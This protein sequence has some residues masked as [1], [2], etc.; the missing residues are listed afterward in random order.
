[1]SATARKHLSSS[2]QLRV[3]RGRYSP[4]GSLASET[5]ARSS[6][7]LISYKKVGKI[8]PCRRFRRI[9]WLCAAL[10]LAASSLAAQETPQPK[11]PTGRVRGRV[12]YS[13]T[14]RPVRLA[15][16]L[17]VRA[18]REDAPPGDR[19]GY[20]PIP[21]DPENQ[22]AATD[23][24]G[25]FE[26]EKAPAGKY[27][28]ILFG[29]DLVFDTGPD[30]AGDLNPASEDLS[31]RRLAEHFP[32]VTVRENDTAE[33]QLTGRRGG[34]IAGRVTKPDGSPV[35]EAEVTL[36]RRSA[37]GKITKITTLPFF[38][39]LPD[40]SRLG[41]R[42]Q[43][44]AQGF[45]RLYGLPAGEYLLRAAPP[46][47]RVENEEE[48][49]PEAAGRLFYSYFPAGRRAKQATPVVVQEGVESPGVDV[50]LPDLPARALGGAVTLKDAPVKGAK[51]IVRPYD[52]DLGEELSGFSQPTDEAG[53]WQLRGLPDGVY[54]LSVEL[55]EAQAKAPDG[56]FAEANAFAGET[57][58]ITLSGD[59]TDVKLPLKAGGVVGGTV[60]AVG[61]KEKHPLQLTLIPREK[62][63]PT[64]EELK[65]F[66]Q[67][68]PPGIPREEL[69]EVWESYAPRPPPSAYL[70][71]PGAFTIARLKP[72][73]YALSLSDSEYYIKQITRNGKP[74]P[75]EP[76]SVGAGEEMTDLRIEVADDKASLE[77]RAFLD[78]AH[79]QPLARGVVYLCAVKDRLLIGG[80]RMVAWTDKNGAF[81][82]NAPPGEYYLIALPP[83]AED[84][85]DK[86][87][88]Q[89]IAKSA[90]RLP[91][92]T[93]K[94]NGRVENL[95]VKAAKP[96]K[97]E[98]PDAP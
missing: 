29:A 44:D 58:E 82:L 89:L 18:D 95:L 2:R 94:P 75:D 22:L 17:L 78:A 80:E 33:M 59:L 96:P 60:V 88:E 5:L 3:T 13:D 46:D 14:G 67:R 7:D 12:T 27:A 25:E 86:L 50:T 57:K 66:A 48:N 38:L 87:I 64:D 16:V 53:A 40:D 32:T 72:G 34:V 63:G 98:K 21:Y 51:V 83:T 68:F 85:A 90:A 71:E 74:L 9:F 91:R 30:G 45:Y 55:G 43:A 39:S 35:P 20:A 56:S 31:L 26:L 97:K 42:G 28:V 62:D 8:M 47:Y 11:P 79:R 49:I 23:M 84:D 1:M 19:R 36:L 37:E 41:K 93:L 77:G 24:A 70:H 73:R 92:L 6:H 69:V 76:L 54:R 61:G 10:C 52:P 15:L 81:G 65:V 4:F